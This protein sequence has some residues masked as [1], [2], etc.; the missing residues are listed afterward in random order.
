MFLRLNS[1]SY[2]RVSQSFESRQKAYRPTHLSNGRGHRTR[3][4]G[5][6]H[7]YAEP[8]GNRNDWSH[9]RGIGRRIDPSPNGLP[10][11]RY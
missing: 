11:Y 6:Q 4:R 10:D 9:F 2:P 8:H 5:E 7:D 3:A 1:G